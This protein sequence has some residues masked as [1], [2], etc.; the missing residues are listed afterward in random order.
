VEAIMSIL[1]WVLLVYVFMLIVAEVRT[2]LHFQ[3]PNCG[4]TPREGW[5]TMSMLPIGL[6]LP[7]LLLPIIGPI[8][9]LAL[10][11]VD[12]GW[13]TDFTVACPGCNLEY[14]PAHSGSGPVGAPTL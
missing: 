13:F 11:A 1:I 7:G 9:V 3:C 12:P 8:I 6:G 10:V 5:M 4:R 14:H 2:Y